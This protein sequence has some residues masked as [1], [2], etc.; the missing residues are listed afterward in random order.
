MCEEGT[1]FK[2]TQVAL[3]CD[4]EIRGD[5][6]AIR[7]LEARLGEERSGMV[8]QLIALDQQGRN[9]EADLRSAEVNARKIAAYKQAFDDQLAAAHVAR[10]QKADSERPRLF[11]MRTN[12]E[13]E[14]LVAERAYRGEEA[15]LKEQVEELE[16]NAAVAKQRRKEEEKAAQ[17]REA[18]PQRERDETFRMAEEAAAKA[19]SQRFGRFRAPKIR[20]K[21]D[22][23]K[24]EKA[25]ERMQVVG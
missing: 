9:I 15:V 22:T 12:T 1:K 14:A 20:E 8:T 19:M 23:A 3:R 13:K 2:N 24:V 4:Y 7:D 17:R 21:E 6:A 18:D 11:G 16:R 10:L 5:F 25:D